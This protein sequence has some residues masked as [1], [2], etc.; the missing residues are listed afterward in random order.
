MK[1]FMA[2]LVASASE[3]PWADYRPANAKGAPVP[4]Y[5][6]APHANTTGTAGGTGSPQGGQQGWDAAVNVQ[7]IPPSNAGTL[8]AGVAGTAYNP[9][10]SGGNTNAQFALIVT[11]LVIRNTIEA[12][13]QQP[14]IA[15]MGSYLRAKNVPGTNKFVYT[16]FAD[17]SPAQA[18]LEGVPPESERLQFDAQE[19]S[20]SQKGK[21]VAIT[22]L[23]GLISPFDLY[24]VA[25]EKVAWNAVDTL[26]KDLVTITQGADNG[27]GLTSA[28]ATAVD[29]VT[30]YVVGMKNALVPMFPD[31]TYHAVVSPTDAAIIMKEAGANGWT[32]TMKYASPESLLNGEIG[33]FR[34]VRF[35]ESVRVADGKSVLFGP[36][37]FAWGDYQTIQAYRV[38]PGGDHADPLAQRGLVGWKG[39]WGLK[40]VA[41]SGTPAVGPASNTKGERWT[42]ADFTP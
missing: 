37:F 35:I 26:E 16:A 40:T 15:Q 39:M 18:L 42:Q 11:Q 6:L 32:D 38:A 3:S 34:G 13:R 33:R 24:S 25:A 4:G 27:I 22:D 36:D 41:F 8:A 9:A 23:A 17:L 19:L 31:G 14:V 2:G 5:I 29:R 12:L 21:L 28:A 1:E 20:G 30:D 10:T 7:P